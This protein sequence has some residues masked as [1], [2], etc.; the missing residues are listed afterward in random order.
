MKKNAV[1]FLIVTMVS[2]LVFA[3]GCK[4]S[5]TV[6]DLFTISATS[7]YSK[8]VT[9]LDPDDTGL[10][11]INL[12]LAIRNHGDVGG[13]ITSWSFEIRHNIVTLVE[14]NRNNYQNYKLVVSGDMTVPM[15]E[16]KEFYVNTPQPFQQ[17]ALTKD[18]LSF[19]PY[20]PTSVIAEIEITDDNG[21]IHSITAIGSFTYEQ[22]KNSESKYDIVGDWE[23]K[24]VVNGQAKEKQKMVFVGTK[25]GGRYALY[26]S[27]SNDVDETGS[28]VVTNYKYLTFSSDLGTQYWGEFSDETNMNGTL[29]IPATKQDDSKTGTYTGKKL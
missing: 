21:D 25:V 5:D 24:R 15:D 13:T 9:T 17:N 12:F 8:T 29:M 18:E 14:I 22:G 11:S 26:K 19:E 10:T 6:V 27:G 1:V 4:T 2:L 28:Y 16:V 23:F 3:N 7:G 20:T